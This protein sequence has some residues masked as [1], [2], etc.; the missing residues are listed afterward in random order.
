MQ[1]LHGMVTLQLWSTGARVP[2]G[3]WSSCDVP[4]N[5][6]PPHT[7]ANFALVVHGVCICSGVHCN[8]QLTSDSYDCNPL[9]PCTIYHVPA[10]N[11]SLGINRGPFT[12]KLVRA[13]TC[14][15][16]STRRLAAH[17]LFAIYCLVHMYCHT[18]RL[19]VQT[20][21]VSLPV[22][23]CVA[24]SAAEA[25]KQCSNSTHC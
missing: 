5:H 13:D 7:K 25:G 4:F 21:S 16:L 22:S 10:N 8:E 23:A 14:T 18:H 15:V 6:Q 19:C 12:C 1:Y 2:S 20:H 11:T 3:R 24:A 17:S 9:R